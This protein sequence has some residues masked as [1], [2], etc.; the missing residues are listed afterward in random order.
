MAGEDATL[1]ED[2]WSDAAS[3]IESDGRVEA[4]SLS[5]ACVAGGD[6]TGSAGGSPGETSAA[7]LLLA[8]LGSWRGVLVSPLMCRTGLFDRRRRLGSFDSRGTWATLTFLAAGSSIGRST[9]S[10]LLRLR[11]FLFVRGTV[12]GVCEDVDEDDEED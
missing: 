5:V 6:E 1:A 10:R 9:S 11:S 3:E 12:A 4:K 8:S 2:R 7:A